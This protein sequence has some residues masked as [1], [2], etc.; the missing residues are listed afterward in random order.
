MEYL[1]GREVG[2]PNRE[3]RMS[4]YSGGRMEFLFGREDEVPIREGE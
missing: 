4:S 2:V 1:I 3:G